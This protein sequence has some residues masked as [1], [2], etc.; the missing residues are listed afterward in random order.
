MPSDLALR[1]LRGEQE[2]QDFVERLFGRG[3]WLHYVSPLD[4]DRR[5][6][7]YG[8]RVAKIR[9]RRE[10]SPV[11]GQDLAHEFA[12]L[13]YLRDSSLDRSPAYEESGPW[14]VLTFRFVAGTSFTT[15]WSRRGVLGRCRLIAGLARASIELNRVGVSHGNLSFNNL[16]LDERGAVR[17]IDFGDARVSGFAR[18][19]LSDQVSL[20]FGRHGLLI[21]GLKQLLMGAVPGLASVYRRRKLR[22][23]REFSVGDTSDEDLRRLER[24]WRLT[25][26]WNTT[27]NLWLAY[28]SLS[29]D[30]I[31][32]P[33]FRPWLLR[34][35][36]I[37]RVVSFRNR[38]VLDLG[39]NVGLLCSFALLEGA[40]RAHGVDSEPTLTEGARA[41]AAAFGVP[42]TFDTLDLN[43]PEAWEY[44]L[45]GFDVVAA[46]S[47]MEWVTDRARL[48]RFLGEHDELLYEGHDPLDVEIDR[49]MSVGF[50]HFTLIT[51]SDRGR[52]LLYARK[53]AVGATR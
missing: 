31:L 27:L 47:I 4:N 38:A 18:A 3:A 20:W 49:L 9:R 14:Q 42:A 25:A 51:V 40:A 17:I 8:D 5:L 30:G 41:A 19:L 35:D 12:V 43:S 46:L 34:W 50:R 23:V 24:A 53:N 15:E 26:R 39:T 7:R 16:V 32:F 52:A 44:R 28:S 33:G 48:V 45:R 6:Y 37:K 29:V 11:Y 21:S 2:W 13:S 10:R 22:V 36:A 1:L